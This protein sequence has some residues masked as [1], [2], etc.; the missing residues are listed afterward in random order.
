MFP[1]NRYLLAGAA[2]VFA[3]PLLL[4]FG[5]P[6]VN[7]PAEWSK[8]L[9][10]DNH[11]AH[12]PDHP[13]H[14][15]HPTHR[16]PLKTDRA[17]EIKHIVRHE[18]HDQAKKLQEMYIDQSGTT[19]STSQRIRDKTEEARKQA[20]DKDNTWFKYGIHHATEGGKKNI[21]FG[22]TEHEAWQIVNQLKRELVVTAEEMKDL[23]KDDVKDN[24]WGDKNFLKSEMKKVIEEGQ[25]IVE[26]TKKTPA[27]R[28]LQVDPFDTMKDNTIMAHKKA[29]EMETANAHE[30]AHAHAHSH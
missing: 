6:K 8:E 9:S 17:S 30:H 28:S 24:K 13:D 15:H 16:P 29:L 18:G 22:K 7:V 2:A 21:E 26:A 1:R 12:P 4:Y 5:R 20:A 3:S 10:H 11:S 19:G 23:A 27:S 25:V 14:P